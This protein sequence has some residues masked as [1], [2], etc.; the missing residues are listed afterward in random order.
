MPA[1][2]ASPELSPQ[3]FRVTDQSFEVCDAHTRTPALVGRRAV[4]RRRAA[5]RP[6]KSVSTHARIA[7][8]A[9]CLGKRYAV[10]GR[11]S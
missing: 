1:G 8:P 5:R 2:F 3:V 7:S 4:R 9:S 10:L 11:R 6:A